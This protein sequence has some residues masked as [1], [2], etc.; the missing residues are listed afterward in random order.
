MPDYRLL[1]KF[2]YPIAIEDCYNTYM[3][4]LENAESMKIKKNKSSERSSNYQSNLEKLQLKLQLLT[5]C[6]YKFAGR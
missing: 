6:F 4:V 3:W 1:P 2:R 5:P